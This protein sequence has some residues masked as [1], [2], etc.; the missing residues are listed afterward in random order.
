M[1]ALGRTAFQGNVA[2]I[3]HIVQKGGKDLLCLG[4]ESGWTPL[5]C[6]ANCL[7]TEKGFLA[8]KALLSLG[9]E[10]NTATFLET[11]NQ[12]EGGTPSMATPLWAAAVKTQNIKLVKLLLI[13][14]G[15]I[16]PDTEQGIIYPGTEEE[17][18]LPLTLIN[19]AKA[20]LTEDGEKWKL[21]RV[22]LGKTTGVK[23]PPAFV[24][25]IGKYFYGDLRIVKPEPK[26]AESPL[27]DIFN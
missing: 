5:Y 3:H 1:T 23:L 21:F 9:A 13:H 17:R 22:F 14:G 7:S 12:T 26:P 2:L 10:I 25:L 19:Q 15:A 24:L 11:F 16:H 6:A 20:E 4:N 18:R 8:A 27:E